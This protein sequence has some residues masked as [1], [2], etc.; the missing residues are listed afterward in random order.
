MGRQINFFLSQSEQQQF[1]EVCDKM[2]SVAAIEQPSTSPEMKL[3]AVESVARWK[4]GDHSPF[5]LMPEDFRCIVVTKTEVRVPQKK[6]MY[7]VDVWQSPVVEF[8]RCVQHSDS[9]QRGRLFFEPSFIN[10]NSV[11][12]QKSKLFVS[13]ASKLFAVI[14]KISARDLNGN[15]VGKK[16]QSLRD[17]GIRLREF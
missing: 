11:V 2:S 3:V 4:I 17:S 6:T 7:F 16:A 12:V 1:C 13:W 5:L 8:T 15:Y 10:A 14:K 9:I